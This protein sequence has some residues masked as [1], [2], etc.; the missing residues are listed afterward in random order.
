MFGWETAFL[1]LFVYLVIFIEHLL[2]PGP[3]S[4]IMS[5]IDSVL[6]ISGLAAYG[7]DSH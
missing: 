5:K 2:H 1:F 6:V 3:V 7:T 4:D